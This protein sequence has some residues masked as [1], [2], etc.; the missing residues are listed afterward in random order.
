MSSSLDAEA[1][2]DLVDVRVALAQ[3]FEEQEYQ[4]L[5]NSQ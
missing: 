4:E 1:L 5:I 3:D 2:R